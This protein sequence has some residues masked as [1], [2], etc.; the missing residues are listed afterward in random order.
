VRE[1]IEG[2]HFSESVQRL[3]GYRAIDLALETVMEALVRNPY[4][5]PSIE[6][7][8]VRIRYARTRMIEGYIPPL[9]VA[10]TIDDDNNVILQWADLADDAE[11]S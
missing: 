3:G 10:F 2:P 4:G 7:D 9:I 5:F 8:W 1:I 11:A 6:N